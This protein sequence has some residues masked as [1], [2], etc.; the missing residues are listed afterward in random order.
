MAGYL[1]DL[2]R[3]TVLR[4]MKEEEDAASGAE[5]RING[6]ESLEEL[7]GICRQ[8]LAGASGQKRKKEEQD[9]DALKQSIRKTVAEK[10]SRQDFNLSQLAEE[11]QVSENR[12]YK[13]FKSLFG[14]SFSEYLE[15]ERIK[16]ACEL[17]KKQV[18]VKDV[19]EAVGY[20]SDF[21]FRRAFKRVMGLAPSYY[22]EGL[23]NK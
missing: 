6:A 18:P 11:L 9:A 10:Y 1:T 20:G 3:A 12:L 21:S 4:A 8:L 14:M 5:E 22:A 7:A 15:N 23:D 17:L 2:V 13:Q 16:M 19:A